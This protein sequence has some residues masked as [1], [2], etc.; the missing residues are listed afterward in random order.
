MRPAS[1]AGAVEAIQAMDAADRAGE[2]YRLV[3]TDANMPEVDGFMLAERIKREPRLDG[4]V[5]MMLSSGDRPSEVGRCEQLG[6]TSYLMKPVKQSELFDAI[7]VALGVTT[8]GEA[9]PVS[10]LERGAPHRPL[11]IL[12]AEDSIVN[13]KLVMGLLRRQGHVVT[14]ANHGKEAVAACLTQQFDVVLMDVQ[15]PE[16]DGLEATAAIR[17]KEKQIGRHTP[18]IAMTAYAMKGDRERC[19]EAGMDCYVAKPIRAKQLFDTIEEALQQSPQPQ[20]PV[21]DAGGPD[22]G[23]SWSV[24][25]EAVDGDPHLLRVVVKTA[26][27]EAPRLIAA[28]RQAIEDRNPTALR[29]AAHTLKGSIRCFGDGPVA[30]TVT[31]LERMGQAS[32]E[33]IDDA[34][35][36][37][38]SQM[39]Q[40]CGALES[41]LQK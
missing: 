16:M 18:I 33:G 26:L 29:L 36:D 31:R 19:L 3:L 32:W 22:D 28:I 17:A 39:P 1:V 34:A 14:V 5:I 30:E 23:I 10:P 15:M 8:L 13:Q 9:E 38:E 35:A 12:L 37:L 11:R 7:L 41:Y 4:T 6:I 2:P 40:F 20:R 27:E 24:A 21:V 25:L